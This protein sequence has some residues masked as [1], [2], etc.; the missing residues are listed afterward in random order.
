MDTRA[1]DY[2]L[3]A[4]YAIAALFA[5]PADANLNMV[6]HPVLMDGVRPEGVAFAGTEFLANA[7]T[8]FEYFF[9][10]SL[11]KTNSVIISVV[12]L[13]GLVSLM[14]VCILR[15]TEMVKQNTRMTATS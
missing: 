14:V 10:P 7:L 6:S 8:A 2:N 12:G 3:M 15:C 4:G 11:A 13:V 1:P 9:V 5:A